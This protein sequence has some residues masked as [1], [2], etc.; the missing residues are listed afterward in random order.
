MTATSAPALRLATVVEQLIDG[1]SF[2]APGRSGQA[3]VRYGAVRA[4]DGPAPAG[5][6]APR[7]AERMPANPYRTISR[8]SGLAVDDLLAS[9]A[10]GGVNAAHRKVTHDSATTRHRTRSGSHCLWRRR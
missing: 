3:G 1:V 5:G 2:D 6:V 7:I 10:K 8:T 9:A 4:L